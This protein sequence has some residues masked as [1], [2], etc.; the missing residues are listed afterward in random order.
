MREKR[1]VFTSYS[2]VEVIGL[3]LSAGLTNWKRRKKHTH[4]SFRI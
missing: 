3:H 2:I 1:G 4:L